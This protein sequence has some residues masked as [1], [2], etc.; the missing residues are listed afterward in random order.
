MKGPRT[1]ELSGAAIPFRVSPMLAILV[2]KPFDKPGWVY[3]EKYDGI[4]LLA[5]K[6]GERVKLISR[7][8]I[9]R[10][11]SYPEVAAAIAK[12]RATSLLLDG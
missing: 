3:E 7:N 9:D 6:E 11:G 5:Y 10:S 1:K 4:R 8:D 2:D 12:L